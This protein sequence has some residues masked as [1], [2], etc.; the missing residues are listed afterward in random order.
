MMLEEWSNRHN[1][2]EVDK[3]TS[4]SCAINEGE[5][6]QTKDATAAFKQGS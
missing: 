4:R 3:R 5:G 6:R 2:L 1:L